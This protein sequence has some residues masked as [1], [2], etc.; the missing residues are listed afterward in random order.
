MPKV[1]L[2]TVGFSL[3]W[4]AKL[5]PEAQ[6]VLAKKFRGREDDVASFGLTPSWGDV[7]SLRV[8]DIRRAHGEG[9]PEH[10]LDSNEVYPIISGMAFYI[11]PVYS[12]GMAASFSMKGV[13]L[14]TGLPE[15]NT[16]TDKPCQS[17]WSDEA[18]PW[19]DGYVPSHGQAVRQFVPL[20]GEK[21][22]QFDVSDAVGIAKDHPWKDGISAAFFMPRDLT[23]LE[24]VRRNRTEYEFLGGESLSKGLKSYGG[25]T[26]GATRSFRPEPE[27]VGMG[28]G[29][30]MRQQH[31][32][33]P[34]VSIK[35]FSS[36]L[37]IRLTAR[38]VCDD[39]FN[40]WARTCGE[41]TIPTSQLREFEERQRAYEARIWQSLGGKPKNTF[42]D[43]LPSMG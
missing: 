25:V 15:E 18:P 41:R 35:D 14:R 17:Y 2:G 20:R 16:L 32:D 22:M 13:N 11:V 38:L 21:A 29:A 39:Q 33:N 37:L 28:A 1:N 3:V 12:N 5:P 7:P 19:I 8:A 27:E 24:T 43:D 4:T 30:L 36:E 23:K 42:V 9:I 10:W 31:P 40:V 6:A 34:M 26:R